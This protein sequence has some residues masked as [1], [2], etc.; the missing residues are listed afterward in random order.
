MERVDGA[1]VIKDAGSARTSRRPCPTYC[2]TATH[3]WPLG[4]CGT[5]RLSRGLPRPSGSPGVRINQSVPGVDG[6]LVALRPDIV[7]THEPSRTIVMV[8]VTVPFENKR[9]ALEKARLEKIQK[10]RPLADALMSFVVGALGA[11][12]THNDFLCSLLRISPGYASLMRKLMVSE[13]I[14]STPARANT[15]AANALDT[16]SET[17]A[18]QQDSDPPSPVN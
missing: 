15:S 18:A 8:D 11:W 13:T 16:G 9:E 5:T 10:Y 2:V 3:I 17:I 7:I 12:H 4:S 1:T 6:D 14:V